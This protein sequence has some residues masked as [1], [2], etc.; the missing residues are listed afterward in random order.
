MLHS[1]DAEAGFVPLNLE[2]ASSA[3]VP[4]HARRCWQTGRGLECCQLHKQ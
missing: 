4:E 3:P 1:A 2:A